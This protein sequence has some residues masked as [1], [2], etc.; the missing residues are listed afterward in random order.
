MN[1]PEDLVQKEH[2]EI[3]CELPSNLIYEF[4]GIYYDKDEDGNEYK[5][6]LSMENTLWA[7]TIL[8]S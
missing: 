7:N 8:A 5:E 4:N 6:A 1:V 3:R 2:A